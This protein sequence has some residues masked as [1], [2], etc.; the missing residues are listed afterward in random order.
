MHL[1][2]PARKA[3][4]APRR[5]RGGLGSGAPGLRHPDGSAAP[6]GRGAAL[7]PKF[8]LCPPRL[9]F[10]LQARHQC[11]DGIPASSHLWQ[12][13]GQR[14]LALCQN[15][16]ARESLPSRNTELAG[17]PE[18]GR[19]AS[20]LRRRHASRGVRLS[21]LHANLGEDSEH[22]QIAKCQRLKFQTADLST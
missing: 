18:G 1:K 9:G 13:R 11:A 21:T 19:C 22:T 14:V 4:T 20:G 15:K 10:S 6:P 2:A 16:R 17:P 8:G 7:P 3:T 12:L 5:R